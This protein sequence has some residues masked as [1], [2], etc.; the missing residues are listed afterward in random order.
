M[1]DLFPSFFPKPLARFYFHLDPLLNV[2]RLHL[3]CV[4]K[5]A[6]N[7][8]VR[9]RQGNPNSTTLFMRMD[10]LIL[11]SALKQD[12]LTE[13]EYAQILTKALTTG[14]PTHITLAAIRQWEN[15][16]HSLL[17][18]NILAPQTKGAPQIPEG[19][20]GKFQ[21]EWLSYGHNIATENA[22]GLPTEPPLGPFGTLTDFIPTS[23][24]ATLMP[25]A[26]ARSLIK[27]H[28]HTLL[29][30]AGRAVSYE[31]GTQPLTSEVI[32]RAADNVS[33]S[34]GRGVPLPSELGVITT[35]QNL[36]MRKE[37]I[38]EGIDLG[39]F[40]YEPTK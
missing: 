16:D 15:K 25:L 19:V 38:P 20:F 6:Y 14:N 18:H 33:P 35:G 34:R 17:T 13:L 40:S 12:L 3:P 2:R 37:L 7:R 23:M 5:A 39:Y 26:Q 9:I 28:A 30:C 32:W 36:W 22:Q 31:P 11:L 27:Q 29:R 10:Y 4:T 24:L 21:S 1:K 8:D